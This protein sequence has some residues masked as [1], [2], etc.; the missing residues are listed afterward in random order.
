MLSRYRPRG[1]R[2]IEITAPGRCWCGQRRIWTL[3]NIVIEWTWRSDLFSSWLV[4]NILTIWRLRGMHIR[5]NLNWQVTPQNWQSRQP[6]VQ[7]RA[8]LTVILRGNNHEIR[9]VPGFRE[10]EITAPGRCRCGQWRIRTL[11]NIVIE[12]P[13]RTA[14]FSRKGE[15]YSPESSKHS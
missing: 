15:N 2:E 10:I 5:N 6:F 14:L 4:V 12:W 9:G 1:F 7:L 11:P 13:C 3:P 8:E